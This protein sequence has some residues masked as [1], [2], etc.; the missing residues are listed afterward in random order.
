MK[1]NL[2]SLTYQK[3]P[4]YPTM[5]LPERKFW[6]RPG[7]NEKNGRKNPGILAVDDKY[8][9]VAH[10]CS[11]DKLSW[12]YVCKYRKTCKVNCLSKARVVFFDNRWI[13]QHSDDNHSCEPN[14]A[15]VTA[16]FLRHRM[17]LLIRTDRLRLVGKFLE[18]FVLK[19]G[20]HGAPIRL[21]R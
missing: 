17:K 16:E 15:K 13:L 9:Y 12:T 19:L 14:R 3:Y 2:N 11:R 5:A 6:F 18:K 10:D 4:E 1:L 20:L 8:E 7:R 21:L